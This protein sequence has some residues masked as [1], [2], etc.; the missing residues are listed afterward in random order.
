MNIGEEKI[1]VSPVYFCNIATQVVPWPGMYFDHHV[2]VTE[3]KRNN[4][5]TGLGSMTSARKH[6]DGCALRRRLWVRESQ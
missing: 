1:F 3:V 2:Q 6:N 5:Q 4:A